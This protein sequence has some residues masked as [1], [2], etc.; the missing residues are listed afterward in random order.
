[1]TADD[2][3]KNYHT[4]KLALYFNNSNFMSMKISVER[5]VRLSRGTFFHLLFI[6]AKGT[7]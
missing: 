3:I 5:K 1:M 2:M 7:V 6:E 4:R